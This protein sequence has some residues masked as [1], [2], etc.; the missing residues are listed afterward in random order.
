MRCGGII[1]RKDNKAQ[2]FNGFSGLATPP[3]V[4]DKVRHYPSLFNSLMAARHDLRFYL[5][6]PRNLFE[7]LFN[8]PQAQRV[9]NLKQA[10]QQ[11]SDPGYN[12]KVIPANKGFQRMINAKMDPKIPIPRKLPQSNTCCLF[13]SSA[14]PMATEERKRMPKPM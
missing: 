13:S 2:L 7:S 10:H 12:T 4:I 14:Q 11:E 6:I 1:R 9:I 5:G 3:P 8:L